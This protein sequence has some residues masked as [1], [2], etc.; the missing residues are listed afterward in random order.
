[1]KD[2]I[3]AYRWQRKNHTRGTEVGVNMECLSISAETAGEGGAAWEGR[4]PVPSRK[5]GVYRVINNN[6]SS[7]GRMLCR[8]LI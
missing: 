2:R 1:M 3:H 5:V 6:Q 4:R 8:T 7:L